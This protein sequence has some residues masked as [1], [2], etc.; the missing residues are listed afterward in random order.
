LEHR[1]HG[2]PVG[3]DGC[4]IIA[5]VRRKS[6]G[7]DFHLGLVELGVTDKKSPNFQLIDDYAVWLVNNR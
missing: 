5:I 4:D 2:H 6:D 7:K 1:A 3:G